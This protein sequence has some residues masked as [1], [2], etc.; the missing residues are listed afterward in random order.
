MNDL[1]YR[2]I[3]QG[4]A[5]GIDIKKVAY[6]L[7]K[8][9]G[10]PLEAI[11]PLLISAPR[12]VKDFDTQSR[13]ETAQRAMAQMG[14][15][16]VLEPVV[17]YADTPYAIAQKHDRRIRGELS[18]VLRSRSSMS[19]L[20][21]HVDAGSAHTIYPSM[22]GNIEDQ[23]GEIFRESDTL[24][25]IDDHRFILLGF[26]TDRH[27]VGPMQQ[28]TLRGLKK[29]LDEKVIVTCGYAV[30]PEEGQTLGKLLYLTTLSRDATESVS[31]QGGEQAGTAVVS[32]AT[33]L[34]H[35]GDQWTPLQLCFIK[36]RGRIFHR[37]LSMDPEMLWL[38]LAQIPHSDQKD[39]LA[40]LPFDSPLVPVLEKIIKDQ[41]KPR[42]ALEAE[43]HF[44]AI[45]QQM[46]IE[47]GMVQ[48]A[49]M[50]DKVASMLNQSED[51]PT[52]PTVASQIF[53]IASHPY[54]SGTELAD[55]ILKDPALTSKL[56]KTV[57]SAFYGY[58]QQISSVKY[59]ISLLGTNEIVDIAFGLAAARV[60]DS[61]YL[62][63]IIDPQSLWHHSL[64][65]AM[66]VKHL[67]RKLPG[68]KD[69]GVF[70]AGLLHDAGKIFFIDHFT[71]TYRET[72]LEAETQGQ[73]LFELE[74]EFYGMDHAMVGS[75]LAL[76]WNLPE[77]L[78]QAIAYH[79]QPF[80]APDHSDLA[81]VTGLANYLYYR[82][83]AGDS[84]P[85]DENH[86]SHGMT[87]G[88]WLLLSRLFEHFDSTMLDGLVKEA[89]IIIDENSSSMVNAAQGNAK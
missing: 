79:H 26:A 81:A 39:F 24:I 41:L 52:L 70:S 28:K 40:R 48:R 38:G 56:L 85:T 34:P 15:L 75:S 18:K 45:I 74:E 55:I 14:C 3:F 66:L 27:G 7:Q 25:G 76:R 78:V 13:A 65:T 35:T 86:I 29:I 44:S 71:D 68:Q 77:T 51:L 67:Y 33:P 89:K 58:P 61:K 17:Q 31:A 20:I 87:Y 5:A 53:N 88:H 49:V 63:D 47:S 9:I 23:L 73:S 83:M 42:P 10:L 19:I 16:T 11:R 62:R 82:A 37:L 32:A 36:G 2:L 80:S 69:E 6:S 57:N 4:F 30:F 46:E 1:R 22:L 8:E 59:A 50:T 43:R 21:F 12:V 64:C 54:S 72:Y 84:L 60:F